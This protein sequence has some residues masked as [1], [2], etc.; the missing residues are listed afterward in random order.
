MA[1]VRDPYDLALIEGSRAPLALIATYGF[2]DCSLKALVRT[3]FGEIVAG[4][5]LPIDLDPAGDR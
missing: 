1:A 5:R 4:G 2:R 3:L